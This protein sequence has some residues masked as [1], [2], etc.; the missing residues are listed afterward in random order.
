MYLYLK[1][2][3]AFSIVMN[4]KVLFIYNSFKLFNILNEIK[5]NINFEIYKIDKNDFQKVDIDKSKN[6]LVI[7]TTSC[8]GIE[9]CIKLENLPLKLNKLMEK[10]NISFLKNQYN[11][12]SELIIGKYTLDLNSRKIIFKDVSF[13]LTEKESDLLLFMKNNKKVSLKELQKNVWGHSTGLE[14]HTVET[15]I[16]RLR[17][18]I[19]KNFK[20]NNFIEHDKEGYYL[21]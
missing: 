8:D 18:K 4:S 10:L 2:L 19:L 7:T 3:F 12:Q 11:N 16:Y 5:H 17:K 6:Y 20:D 1:L 13:N 21:N 9:N 15:H 14:T